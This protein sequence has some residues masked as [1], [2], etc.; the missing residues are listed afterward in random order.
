MEFAFGQAIETGEL[1]G[2]GNETAIQRDSYIV[3][4]SGTNR[5]R[6]LITHLF[7]LRGRH[8]IIDATCA[9]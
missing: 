3:M 1:L 7:C 9:T 6:P 2:R 4:Q 8:R 5:F